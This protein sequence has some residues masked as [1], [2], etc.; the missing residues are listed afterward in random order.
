[1]SEESVVN[2][3]GKA[4]NDTTKR[5]RAALILKLLNFLLPATGGLISALIVLKI[6][7]PFNNRGHYFTW[8]GAAIVV[9]LG[10]ALALGAAMG[11][12]MPLTRLFEM[13]SNFDVELR[14]R[15]KK[16]L[17]AGNPKTVLRSGEVDM[18]REE[19]IEHTL[20]LLDRITRHDRIT[21]GH[22]ERVRAY[23]SLIGEELGFEGERLQKLTWSALLHD[24]G[25]LEVPKSILSS[26]VEPST[27]QWA[28]LKRHPSYAQQ[29]L[30]PLESWLGDGVYHA[31][32][33]HHERWDGTGYPRRIEGADIPLIGRIVSVA[34]AFDVMTHTRSY[35]KPLPIADAKTQLKD[36]AGTQFDPTVVAAFLRIGE[37]RLR[38]VRG[39]AATVAGV[40][41]AG[42]SLFVTSAAQVAVAAA[43]VTGG[44]LIAEPPPT[45]TPPAA[46]AFDN[47]T[48]TTALPTTTTAL[49]TT[50][51][52]TTT[53][54]LITTTTAPTTTTEAPRFITI[55]YS[56]KT[57]EQD[58]QPSTVQ[59][60]RLDVYVDDVL[61]QILPLEEGQRSAAVTLDIT[62][63]SPTTHIVRFDLYDG[64]TLVSSETLPLSL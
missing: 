54:T 27:A 20:Q 35:K 50:T 62:D 42:E 13:S 18:T 1:M 46:I 56:I 55:G 34:D 2:D 22:S 11:R 23:S 47:A 4:D 57:I 59:A 31:A 38:R 8:L 40:S 37:P 14:S 52:P 64:D 21:R 16:S 19:Q 48:T 43:V 6:G 58:G 5:S 15:F 39:W 36:N 12:L 53:T 32:T 45:T 49:P 29:Y 33:F 61:S 30:K 25:K 7:R 41:V 10:V 26:P 60:D 17:R 28:V 44:V 51:V 9:S 3:A 24:V 63:L